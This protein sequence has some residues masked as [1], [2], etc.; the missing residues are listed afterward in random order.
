MTKTAKVLLEEVKSNGYA[1]FNVQH[2]RISELPINNKR[3]VNATHELLKDKQIM[4]VTQCI[5]FDSH[6]INGGSGTYTEKYMLI[7]AALCKPENIGTSKD[8]DKIY[9]YVSAVIRKRAEL[10]NTVEVVQWK[11]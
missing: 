5:N 6:C 2:V 9:K 1:M 8:T 11:Q 3:K 10:K 4:F 7:D